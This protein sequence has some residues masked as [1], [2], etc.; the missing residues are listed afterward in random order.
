MD[1]IT[2]SMPWIMIPLFVVHLGFISPFVCGA[3][4]KSSQLVSLLSM[5]EGR[6]QLVMEKQYELS[7]FVTNKPVLECPIHPP[8]AVEN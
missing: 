2:V 8:G 6:A 1:I 7:S 4:C 5:I 3:S